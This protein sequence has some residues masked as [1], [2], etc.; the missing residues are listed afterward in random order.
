MALSKDFKVKDTINVGVS[1]VFGQG[2]RIGTSGDWESVYPAID[3]WGPILSGGLDI[4]EFFGDGVDG[5]YEGDSFQGT[6]KYQTQNQAAFD[7]TTFTHVEVLGLQVYD[8]PTFNNLTLSGDSLAIQSASFAISGNSS[9]TVLSGA[10]EIL[11]DPAGYGAGGAGEAGKVRIAGDLIVDGDTFTVN[12]TTVSLSDAVIELGQK[13]DGSI[14]LVSEVPGT[15]IGI[16]AGSIAGAS[17]LYTTAGQWDI[18]SSTNINGG[19]NVDGT[20]TL[21]V[22]TLSGGLTVSD[23]SGATINGTTAIN[24]ATTITGATTV[25]GGLNVDGTSTLN[26]VTLSGG[27]TITDDSGATIAGATTITG[28]TTVNG[29][30]N[31]DGTSTLNVVTLSG[32]LTVSDNSGATINGT[33]AINGATTITGTTT[34]NGDLDVDGSTTLNT[35]D[36][37]GTSVFDDSIT[38][39]SSS[40]VTTSKVVTDVISGTID[41]DA[42]NWIELCDSSVESFK[43]IVIAEAT[44]GAEKS[45]FEILGMP[46][47]SGTN[48]NG[49]VF[50]QVDS[51]DSTPYVISQ[52]LSANTVDNK[53]YLNVVRRAAGVDGGVT[54]HINTHTV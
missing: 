23:N 11:I 37:S 54:I 21:N 8:S 29:G 2:I 14:D 16:S 33:T 48:V 53:I 5:I 45:V 32:G 31:V 17:I 42:T 39:N 51:N 24:G 19:L 25:N 9:Q 52:D 13:A 20:S 1:G 36:V 50:G 28:A 6:I 38:Q 18:N 43:A 35:L 7:P 4:S 46:T 26:A 3:A 41:D 34:V 30:L 27:L 40:G 44:G 47:D 10:N 12:S 49:S 22:V 15:G